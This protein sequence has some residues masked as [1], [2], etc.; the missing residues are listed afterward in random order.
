M[1]RDTSCL[2]PLPRVEETGGIPENIPKNTRKVTFGFVSFLRFPFCVPFFP[3]R[4]L[5]PPLFPTNVVRCEVFISRRLSLL[6][7][8]FAVARTA[9][10]L[11]SHHRRV[12]S[13]I[14][15]LST[16]RL[17]LCRKAA[18][19]TWTTPLSSRSIFPEAARKVYKHC[20]RMRSL[21]S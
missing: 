4:T 2:P 1:H 15:F 19:T 8:F 20:V 13:A 7:R 14:R 11:Q 16:S 12:S 6:D 10:S 3:P 21:Q 9:S 17:P 5:Q 18:K